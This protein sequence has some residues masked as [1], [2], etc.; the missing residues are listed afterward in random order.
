MITRNRRGFTLVELIIVIIIIG[1]LA[2]L[3]IPQFITSTEDAK[4][5]TVKANLAVMRN[6]IDLYY[7]QHQSRYPGDYQQNDGTTVAATDV[8]RATAFNSQ[9]VDYSDD[10]GKTDTVLDR[11][12]YQFGPY[13]RNAVPTNPLNN[14]ST[15]LATAETSDAT[16]R[17]KIDGVTGW[18]YST[19]TGQ[20]ISN[21]TTGNSSNW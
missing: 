6:A 11:S 10:T 4:E 19:K 3:A 5:A 20:I 1:I 17:A 15:V 12:T 16:L 18:L 9:I 7:H 2:A 8:L 21:M 13:I 14:L